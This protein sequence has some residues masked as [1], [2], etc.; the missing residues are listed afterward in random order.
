MFGVAA[1]DDVF[2]QISDREVLSSPAR[3]QSHET[4][5]HFQT[6]SHGMAEIYRQSGNLHDGKIPPISQYDIFTFR[7]TVKFNGTSSIDVDSH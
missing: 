3:Q 5:P 6:P 2:S 1:V 4:H 7:F